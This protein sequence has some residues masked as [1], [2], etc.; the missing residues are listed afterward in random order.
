MEISELPV[1]TIEIKNNQPVDLIDL[2]NSFSS[3]GDEYKRYIS[4]ISGEELA[5]TPE[6]I[7]LY[8]KEIRSGSIIADLVA[9]AAGMIP[10]LEHSKT[11]IDF[12][13]YLK[14]AYDYLLG[15]AQAKPSLQKINYQNLSNFLEPI[16][17]DTAAQMNCNTTINGDVTVY[18][19][20]NSLE[21]NA[22]Q[23]TAK[24]EIG[25]LK[26][27]I[28]GIN[29][30]VLLY[31]YQARNDPKSNVGDKAI[32]ESIQSNPTKTIFNNDNIKSQMIYGENPFK[33]AYVVD[34]EIETIQGKPT[35]YKIMGVHDRI[36][37]LP[38]STE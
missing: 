19:T 25:L 12:A 4:R 2:T 17:K 9:F 26:E 34:V 30:K 35:L 24:R 5:S 29:N 20:I 18:L 21:A 28:T 14:G 23:N 27:P 11:V 16:A 38:D 31:W 13:G 1:F 6:E 32:I 7:K 33:S 36:D 15:K 8:I 22:A 3:I 37:K 10:F